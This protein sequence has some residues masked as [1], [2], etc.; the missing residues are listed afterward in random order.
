M[1]SDI[2][3]GKYIAKIWFENKKDLEDYKLQRRAAGQDSDLSIVKLN[4]G[5]LVTV[6]IVF[7]IEKSCE[8]KPV[9]LGN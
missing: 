2:I 6:Y 3:D 4:N 8:N 1:G 5:K 7:G 9:I